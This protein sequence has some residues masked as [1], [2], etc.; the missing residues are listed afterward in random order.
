MPDRLAYIGFAVEL[1]GG[2]LKVHHSTTLAPRLSRIYENMTA[3]E[4]QGFDERR[5]EAA[6]RIGEAVACLINPNARVVAAL[7]DV[8]GPGDGGGLN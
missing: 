5:R 4:R 7:N 8:P 1:D 6:A 2:E 3:A